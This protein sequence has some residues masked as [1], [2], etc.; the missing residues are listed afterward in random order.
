MVPFV[1]SMYPLGFCFYLLSTKNSVSDLWL[2]G[3]INAN[4]F[5]METSAGPVPRLVV[6]Y[7]NPGTYFISSFDSAIFLTFTEKKFA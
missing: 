3:F 1:E 2:V 6:N 4:G 7:V 5:A